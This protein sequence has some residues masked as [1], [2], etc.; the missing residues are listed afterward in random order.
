[1]ITIALL[2][3]AVLVVP[4]SSSPPQLRIVSSKPTTVAGRGFVPGERVSL[5]VL[6]GRIARKELVTVARTG[7]F[8]AVF[9]GLFLDRCGPG[10]TIKAVGRARS[11]ALLRVERLQ[12]V[13]P[14]RSED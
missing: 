10:L 14:T 9:E 4:A 6:A 11:R 13:P 3:A 12:C 1:M 8:R 5:T 7:R 2:A